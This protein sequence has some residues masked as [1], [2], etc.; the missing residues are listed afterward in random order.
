MTKGFSHSYSG[1]VN[2]DSLKTLQK[3]FNGEDLSFLKGTQGHQNL[4]QQRDKGWSAPTGCSTLVCFH[5][6]ETFAIRTFV[7]L[8]NLHLHRTTQ[9][10]NRI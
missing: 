8:Y 5:T 9:I 4:T 2:K 6:N 3:N 10:K 7:T 1:S